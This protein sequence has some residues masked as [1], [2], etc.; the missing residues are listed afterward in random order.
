VTVLRRLA[1]RL[2]LDRATVSAIAAK[3]LAIAAGPVSLV[4]VTRQFTPSIQGYYYTFSSLVALQ[5]FFEL[6]L[7]IVIVNVVS[8][9]WTSL[10]FDEQGRVVGDASSLARLAAMLRLV[11]IWYTGVAVAFLLV[12]GTVGWYFLSTGSS[13]NPDVEWRAP[14]LC[15]VAVNAG[16]LWAMPHKSMLEGSGQIRTVNSYRLAQTVLGNVSSWSVMLL[17]GGL[18]TPVALSASVLLVDISLLYG[19]RGYFLTLLDQVPSPGFNWRTEIWPMQWRLAV[20]GVLFYF[21]FSTFTPVV[22]RYF[23]APAAGQ[24]GMTWQ[25]TSGVMA[26]GSAWIA[27][28]V[29]TFGAMASRRD[30]AALDPLWRHVT[31]VATGVTLLGGTAIIGVA[32]G[33]SMIGSPIANRLL[34]VGAI[35]LVVAGTVAGQVI[36]GI[37]AYL[38]A[39]K[40]DPMAV[41]GVITSIA[42][43]ALVWG[44]GSKF[45][46]WGVAIAYA[47]AMWSVSLPLATWIFLRSRREW[48]KDA[49]VGV[50]PSGE[51]RPETS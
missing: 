33:L 50:G 36:Q 39:H 1:S 43:W 35:A 47:S 10:R 23:G 41:S 7:Y 48:Q 16:V 46:G 34:P 32:E 51:A 13:Q 45:G 19:F 3:L 30:Y 12:A 28:R 42:L 44:L 17:G 24:M 2:A 14:W 6:G 31:L 26:L 9:E 25:A 22:F 38:R 8:H 29:P 49:L 20:Q 37:A 18:W 5:S 21:A 27:S 11:G 40:Q 15:L 4:L